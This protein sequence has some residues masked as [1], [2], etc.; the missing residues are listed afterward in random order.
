MLK[1]LLIANRGEIAIRI[2][3]AAADLGIETVA[4]YTDD[5]ATSLHVRRAD[6]AV[7][8]PGRGGAGYLDADALVTMAQCTGC[9]GVHPGYGFLSENVDFARQ[10]RDAGLVFV[11]PRPEILESFG[12]KVT[13]RELAAEC[14]VPVLPGTVGP[15]D[16]AEARAFFAELPPG[17]AMVIKAVAGGGGRGMRIVRDAGAIETAWERCASEAG[18]AFGNPELYVEQLVERARH[19]E[20][21][22]LGDADGQ[23]SHLWER[24]CTLQRRHQKLIELAP[25]PGLLPETRRGLVEAAVRLAE[26]ARYDNLGT[27]E[28]LVDDAD[29]EQRFVFIE[30]NARL[31]VEHT[32]T[33][34]ITGVDLVRTQ[35][36][37]ATGASLTELGL[38]REQVPAPRGRAVQARVNMETMEVDGSTRPAGGTLTAFEVPT[39]RGVRVETYGYAGYT[40]SPAFDS[41][42]AKVV[43]ADIASD[44]TAV[45]DRAARALEE[46]R[47][48]GV[49]T[50]LEFLRAL[51]AHEAVRN[52]A[53]YTRFV[54]DHTAELMQAMPARH[55]TPAGTAAGAVPGPA[56]G[57]EPEPGTRGISA[58]MQ[59]TV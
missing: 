37:L 24:E 13:A 39:G 38:D 29:P 6:Q 44:L 10:V 59:G 21:Q 57:P 30:A 32:V 16:P 40:T 45:L 49:S 47:I 33:E 4:V 56:P 46:F 52:N 51:L 19:V 14:G 53:V 18:T 17:A 34:E 15:T 27:M 31:Q 22:V 8:L 12:H 36:A 48:E 20:I 7:A 55:A 25:S 50:N 54:E 5:D 41:L 35:I 11:G 58:P 2:A 28:F 9:D 3:R 42:L 26:H 43:V 23:V 1:R